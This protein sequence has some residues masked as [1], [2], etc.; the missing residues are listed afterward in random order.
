M[1][2]L[3]RLLLENNVSEGLNKVVK[4]TLLKF[5]RDSLLLMSLLSGWI[6]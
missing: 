1:S 4:T 3:G 2:L 6:S 5:C